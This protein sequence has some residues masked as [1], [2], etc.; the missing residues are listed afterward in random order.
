LEFLLTR[1]LIVGFNPDSYR[2]RKSKEIRLM[3]AIE[4]K[5]YVPNCI[6]TKH[7]LLCHSLV[8]FVILLSLMQVSL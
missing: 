8:R 1:M 6:A 3:K 7:G 4:G 5:D 2:D